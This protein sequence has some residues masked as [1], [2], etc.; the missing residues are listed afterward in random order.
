[1]RRHSGI[2]GRMPEKQDNRIERRQAGDINRISET[3]RKGTDPARFVGGVTN[4]RYCLA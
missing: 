3:A 1:M 4:R 2:D